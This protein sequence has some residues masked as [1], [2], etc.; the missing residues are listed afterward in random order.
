MLPTKHS[1]KLLR[2]IC[3]ALVAGAI[4][5][6]Q[7]V[8]ASDS[9]AAEGAEVY[10][11]GIKDGDVVSSPVVIRFGLKNMGVSP[12]GVQD[13]E[14][15]GHHHLLVDTELSDE[16]LKQPI[17]SDDNHKHFGKGQT[18]TSLELASG[19]HTLQLVLGDWKHT[20]HTM[21]VMSDKITITVE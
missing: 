11:I 4:A 1:K 13:I 3:M 10:F 21:P 5:L 6:P 16:A 12:A 7:T 15:S 20:P 18:E 9:A 14:N 19:Q 17:P 2:H 8:F